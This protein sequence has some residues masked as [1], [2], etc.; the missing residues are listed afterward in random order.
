MAIARRSRRIALQAI[1][2]GIGLS[3]A[4][5]IAAAAGLLVPLTGA[6]LQEGIDVAAILFALTALR[7]GLR[8]TAP[9]AVPPD[10]GL[11]ERTAEHAG[12][13]QLAERLREVGEAISDGPDA[14]PAVEALVASLG[15]EVVPHQQAEE[16]TLYPAAARRLGGQDPMGPL[17]R[18]H[19]EIE[20]LVAR[21][22][23]LAEL[24]RCEDRW[25]EIAPTLR[26]SLF[27]LEALLSLH[28]S[29]EEEV[30]ADLAAEAV[31]PAP[32]EGRRQRP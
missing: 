7:P 25:T 9:V 21:I 10:A 18:M 20:T 6:L 29:A 28:L 5:M 23:A 14:L 8:D 4:A 30:M 19:T 32:A 26:R 31:H 11:A 13:R 27:A 1:G 22:A 15:A 3:G 17:I 2:L 16:R 12:L 24:V